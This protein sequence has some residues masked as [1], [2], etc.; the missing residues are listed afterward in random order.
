MTQQPAIQAITA[1]LPD[2][3]QHNPEGWFINADAQF[4][5]TKITEEQTKFYHAVRALDPKTSEE[6][7]YFLNE[8]CQRNDRDSTPY[9]NL[10]A[11]LLK[12]YGRSKTSKMS[13]LLSMHSFNENGAES[14]LRRMRVLC[15][16]MDTML[17]C[18]LLSMA[19]PM[20]RTSVASHEFKT[21][22]ELATA[23]D[24]A[25]ERER[26][27]ATMSQS[28]VSSTSQPTVP[29]TSAQNY[30]VAAT[31]KRFLPNKSKQSDNSTDRNLCYYHDRFGYKARKCTGAPCKFAGLMKSENTKASH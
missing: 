7:Q 31:T 30:D 24:E 21:A 22:E 29:P 20:A 13:E 27:T 26:F 3:Y 16:D 14:T 5:L 10:K 6:I 15:T 23:L 28:A 12:V 8:Q 19:S 18:K 4:A 25:S 11:Q 1:K 2:F 17:Q 9:T